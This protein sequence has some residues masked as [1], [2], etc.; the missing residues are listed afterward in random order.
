MWSIIAESVNI[1]ALNF[2]YFC[3][4]EL[5]CFTLI[6]LLSRYLKVFLISLLIIIL[7]REDVDFSF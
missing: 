6:F 5:F 3:K 7:V 2:H 4:G 1:F